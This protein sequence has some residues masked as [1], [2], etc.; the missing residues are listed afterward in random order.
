M[1]ETP[2]YPGNADRLDNKRRVGARYEDLAA[3]YLKEQGL[4]ILERNF[5]TRFGEIDLI[6]QDHGTVVF[7][8]VKYRSFDGRGMPEEA[9]NRKKQAVIRKQAL[10]YL[11]SKGLDD[12]TPCRF[13]V[14][15]VLGDKIRWIP[16]AF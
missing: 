9:V 10:V 12:L 7:T 8:E 1:T 11:A 15:A 5:R 14:I 3:E 6:A 13:D 2:L 16:N 4:R